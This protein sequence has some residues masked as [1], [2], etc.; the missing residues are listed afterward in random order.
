M[1]GR[2]WYVAYGSNLL[3]ER[4]LHYLSGGRF[5][6]QGQSHRGARDTTLPKADR[7]RIV[8]HQLRFGR[9]SQ[10]WG[11][12]VCFLDPEPGSGQAHVRCWS[13]TTEQF[14]D[15]AVQE[16]GGAS[17]D[18]T[19]DLDHLEGVGYLDV[20][21]GWY[22]RLLWLGRMDGDPLLT[23]TSAG[24]TPPRAPGAE[25]LDVVGS[26]LI[27]AGLVGDTEEAAAYLHGCPGVAE[28]WSIEEVISLLG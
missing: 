3:R 26:G 7:C 13:L 28:G 22:G 5:R 14:I 17:D 10:R 27:E 11:G 16:N 9:Q 6:A 20:V 15:V 24:L 12:G 2:V 23:F 18:F 21:E 4:F 1:S 25:Y 8:D 19:M